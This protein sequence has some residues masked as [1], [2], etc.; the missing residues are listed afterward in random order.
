M[1]QRYKFLP[2][3]V[4]PVRRLQD[5][6]EHIFWLRNANVHG[7]P[8]PDPAWLSDVQDPEES[9]YAYQLMEYTEILLRESLLLI[10][11]NQ[12]IFDVFVDARRLDANF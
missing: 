4:R 10:L 8:I 2:H 6:G 1:L 12:V 7:A 9:G 5:I 11:E 3:Q